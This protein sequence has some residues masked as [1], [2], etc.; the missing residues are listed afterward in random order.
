M[1]I[2][3]KSLITDDINESMNRCVESLQKVSDC[4]APIRKAFK[5]KGGTL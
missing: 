2:D 5:Q 4:H 3:F 1:N